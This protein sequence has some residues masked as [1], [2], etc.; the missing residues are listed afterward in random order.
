MLWPVPI[1]SGAATIFGAGVK[2]IR[3]E[4]GLSTNPAEVYR[5]MNC[6]KGDTIRRYSDMKGENVNET[7]RDRESVPENAKLFSG[8]MISI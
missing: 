8:K 4:T 5:I 6:N 1:T 2:K 7:C 3:H